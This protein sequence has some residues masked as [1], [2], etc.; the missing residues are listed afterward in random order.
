VRCDGPCAQEESERYAEVEHYGHGE[1][2]LLEPCGV[3]VDVCDVD[4]VAAE[5]REEVSELRGSRGEGL[6]NRGLSCFAALGAFDGGALLC[7]GSHGEV[8]CRRTGYVGVVLWV[9]PRANTRG[10]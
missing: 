10:I 8:L 7:F 2:A 1:D 9:M 5:C 6:G 4:G 3:C